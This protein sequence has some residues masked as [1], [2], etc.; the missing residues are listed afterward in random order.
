M[1]GDGGLVVRVVL[2]PGGFGVEEVVE[3]GFVVAG[4]GGVHRH[5]LRLRRE[6][7]RWRF[8]GD[9]RLRRRYAG[10][11]LGGLPFRVGGWRRAGEYG[12]A[13]WTLEVGDGFFGMSYEP[14]T[15]LRR[16]SPCRW[17]LSACR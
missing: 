15:K 16:S 3:E 5:Q 1:V 10:E 14:L 6:R 4:I 7:F 17:T 8:R 11:S 9:G 13:V 12:V 2:L